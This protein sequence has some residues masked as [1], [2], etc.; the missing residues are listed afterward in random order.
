MTIINVISQQRK[1]ANNAKRPFLKS[2]VKQDFQ[3][4]PGFTWRYLLKTSKDTRWVLKILSVFT[5]KMCL[6][7]T[8]QE[9]EMNEITNSVIYTFHS[10]T[11]L[12][13]FTSCQLHVQ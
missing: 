6:K 13:P 8:V 7:Q 5:I 1:D 3:V 9:T 2:L 10:V 4:L 11:I 12:K